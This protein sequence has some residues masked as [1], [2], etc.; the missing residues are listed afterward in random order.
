VQDVYSFKYVLPEAPKKSS[1]TK[2]SDTKDKE[3]TKWDEYN[4][5]VRDLKTSWLAKLGESKQEIA[6]D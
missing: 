2:S 3:K 1:N 6:V 5:T 4:E